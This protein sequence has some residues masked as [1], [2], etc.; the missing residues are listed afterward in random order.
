MSDNPTSEQYKLGVQI[1]TLVADA[2][3]DGMSYD[4]VISTLEHQLENAER[5]KAFGIDFTEA[6]T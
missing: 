3:K 2:M 1:G 4:H 5:N 6:A